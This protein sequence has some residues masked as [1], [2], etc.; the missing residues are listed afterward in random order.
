MAASDSALR[1]LRIVRA[2]QST[3]AQTRI[4]EAWAHALLPAGL[5]PGEHESLIGPALGV[6][7]EEIDLLMAACISSGMPE[8]LFA[9][10]LRGIHSAASLINLT[11]PFAAIAGSFDEPMVLVL[12][13]AQWTFRNDASG[14]EEPSE[15]E[16]TALI[17]E[18]SEARKVILNSDL[19]AEV[20]SFL[21]QSLWDYRQALLLS[22]VSGYDQLGERVEA[23]I[24]AVVVREQE[25]RDTEANASPQG[26]KAL[27]K[28]G[29]AFNKMAEV[30]GK[31]DKVLTTGGKIVGIVRGLLGM[32]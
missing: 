22:K 7:R 26:K 28:F 12:N 16:L 5:P 9:H 32:G 31:A 1:I 18:V 11:Q 19:R 10:K 13:W 17:D 14:N 2:M 24:G 25:L 20:K 30:A 21:L 3:H 29:E 23:T 8:E 27:A 6:F 15:A 4:L